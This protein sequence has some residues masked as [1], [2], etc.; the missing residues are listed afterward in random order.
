MRPIKVKKPPLM[1][2]DECSTIQDALFKKDLY[3]TLEQ[4]DELWRMY[5]EGEHC[6]GWVSVGGY[7]DAEIYRNIREYF[8]E[9]P[10][11]SVDTKYL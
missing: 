11:G 2:K 10:A 7:S 4:C 9:W 5:S 1:F 3:A 6:A 8:E